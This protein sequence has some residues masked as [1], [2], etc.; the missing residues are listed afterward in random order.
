MQIRIDLGTRL[1]LNRGSGEF[2]LIKTINADGYLHLTYP[3]GGGSG[4]GGGF[5]LG[6][7]KEF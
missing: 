7:E 2:I 5:I 4:F 6:M 1:Q 3:C